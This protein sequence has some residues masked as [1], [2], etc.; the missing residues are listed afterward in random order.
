MRKLLST[1][2]AFFALVIFTTPAFS[3]YKPEPY[4]AIDKPDPYYISVN[5]GRDVTPTKL[6]SSLNQET[7]T[8]D[9]GIDI[10]GAIG[11]KF[12]MLR[13]EAEAGYHGNKAKEITNNSGTYKL[14]GDF[15]VTSF[16]VNGY[17]DLND[18]GIDI[19]PEFLLLSVILVFSVSDV[20]FLLFSFSVEGFKL[21]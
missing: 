10:I 2:G 14:N 16:F 11:L 8:T 15:G 21:F 12:D 6:T 20:E 18:D 19:E 4:Y 17:L 5:I 9:A 1:L 3:A 7:I 13:L